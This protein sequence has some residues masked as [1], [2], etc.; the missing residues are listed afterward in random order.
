M[1][2]FTTYLRDSNLSY[3]DFSIDKIPRKVLLDQLKFYGHKIDHKYVYGIKHVT[4]EGES[5][6]YLEKYEEGKEYEM[7]DSLTVPFNSFLEHG[8]GLWSFGCI[9]DIIESNR[10]LNPGYFIYVKYLLEDVIPLD[11]QLKG[12]K[13][14][15]VSTD[16]QVVENIIVNLQYKEEDRLL[17]ESKRQ[18]RIHNMKRIENL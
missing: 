1:D 17:I 9:R 10:G 18:R 3:K 6:F 11:R 2:P 7:E 5:T 13:M 8:A 15:V 12:R 16:Q 4:L 14:T